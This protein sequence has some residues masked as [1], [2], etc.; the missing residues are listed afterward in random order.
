MKSKLYISML[1]VFVLIT[2]LTTAKPQRL[3][4]QEKA[5]DTH[6]REQLIAAARE[7]MDA[8]R[9][10]ALVTLDAKGLP[11]T[12]V[13][14]PFPPDDRMVVWLATNPKSR[15]VSQIRANPHVQLFYFDQQ[16]LGYVAISGTALLV[17]DQ[18]E[19]SRRWKEGWERFYA[20]REK[21][22]LLIEVT[23]ERLEVF[24]TRHGI[25]GDPETWT[26]P[27]VAF[28]ASRVKD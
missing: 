1:P 4:G 19:K 27:S 9:Y 21:A 14:D 7:V 20:N 15:K 2:I 24:S 26:L 18:K 8:A 28:E 3:V 25:T 17:D 5:E 13:M 12:R 23:P 22:Y 16:G 11:R 10:C 6:S